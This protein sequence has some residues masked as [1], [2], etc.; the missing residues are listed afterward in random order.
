M[1]NKGVQEVI[2][3]L[4]EK[5]GEKFMKVELQISEFY[6]EEK[7]IVQAPQETKKVQKVIE[8]AK[9]LDQKETIK[10]KIDDQVYLVEIGKIQRFYI[11]NRKV[12]AETASQTYSVDLR[13]YQVLEILPTTF[14]QI[15]Q[16]EIVNIDAISHLKLT[17]NGLVE[18][19]LKNES[20]TYSSRRY[21]KTIKEKLEL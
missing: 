10:G 1:F 15:S 4:Y 14:I 2:T 6:E 21:L 19:F 3:T 13:L 16:S 11:E 18:I 20:F 9:N 8:F 12:L 17:P 7:L 5:Q